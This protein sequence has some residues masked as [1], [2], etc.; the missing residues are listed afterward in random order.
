[1]IFLKRR[2]ETKS[3]SKGE[4]NGREGKKENWMLLWDVK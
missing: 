2:E 3:N 1:M 4:G